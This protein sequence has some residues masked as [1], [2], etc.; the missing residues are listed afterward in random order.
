MFR[1][2]FVFSSFDLKKR[3]LVDPGR[4]ASAAKAL[5]HQAVGARF[6][7]AEG[8]QVDLDEPRAR[9][10]LGIQLELVGPGAL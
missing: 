7:L 4:A 9:E 6:R 2:L 5:Q 8:I 10:G 1:C 3:A